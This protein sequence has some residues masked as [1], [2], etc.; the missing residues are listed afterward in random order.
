MLTTRESLISD[1]RFWWCWFLLSWTKFLTSKAVQAAFRA[2]KGCNEITWSIPG[3]HSQKALGFVTWFL[4]NLSCLDIFHYFQAFF[5][6]FSWQSH[7]IP[8]SA[9]WES[10]SESVY[11]SSDLFLRTQTC[12]VMECCLG[13]YDSA[14]GP[15]LTVLRKASSTPQKGTDRPTGREKQESKSWQHPCEWDGKVVSILHWQIQFNLWKRG[16]EDTLEPNLDS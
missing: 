11:L 13:D 5:F 6:F 16:R 12:K 9:I 1:R 3:E 14:S 4:M 2:N 10:R 15:L 7:S 8:Q